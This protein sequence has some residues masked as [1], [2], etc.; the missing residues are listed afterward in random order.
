MSPTGKAIPAR[1]IHFHTIWQIYT[2]ANMQITC[3][4]KGDQNQQR[5]QLIRAQ[6]KQTMRVIVEDD[7]EVNNQAANFHLDLCA[8]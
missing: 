3:Y 1:Y 2:L 7:A 5:N 6:Q 8:S 4:E